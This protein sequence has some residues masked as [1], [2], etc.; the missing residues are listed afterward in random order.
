M[1]IIGYLEYDV[2]ILKEEYLCDSEKFVDVFKL[3]NYF[4][5]DNLDNELL[6]IW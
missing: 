4:L 1:Y 3:E 5:D 6:K 2:Y